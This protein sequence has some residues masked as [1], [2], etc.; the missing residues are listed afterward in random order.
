MCVHLYSKTIPFIKLFLIIAGRSAPDPE[1]QS[2][3]LGDLV[4]VRTRDAWFV[5]PC[6]SVEEHRSHGYET[7]THGRRYW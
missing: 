7:E 6:P 5:A 2:K 3:G 4:L 1:L